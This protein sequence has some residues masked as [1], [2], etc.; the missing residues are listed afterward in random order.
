M[1]ISNIGT[2]FAKLSIFLLIMGVFFYIIMLLDNTEDT[3]KWNK[4]KT[5]NIYIVIVIVVIVITFILGG[6]DTL[7]RLSYEYSDK[8]EYAYIKNDFDNTYTYVG[9]CIGYE[10]SNEYFVENNLSDNEDNWVLIDSMVILDNR[11]EDTSETIDF[12]KPQRVYLFDDMLSDE[13]LFKP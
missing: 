7:N 13:Q 11:F 9:K 2:F 6:I 5:F 4:E 10:F 1:N 8:V 12:Y 3:K